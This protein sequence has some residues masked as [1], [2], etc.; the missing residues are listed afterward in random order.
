M[1][2]GGRMRAFLVLDEIGDPVDTLAASVKIL[3]DRDEMIAGIKSG[4]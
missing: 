2:L 4:T 3:P 1:D